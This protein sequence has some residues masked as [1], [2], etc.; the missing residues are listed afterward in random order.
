MMTTMN[1]KCISYEFQTL[2]S[3]LY[4]FY[5]LIYYLLLFYICEEY[6]Y[7]CFQRTFINHAGVSVIHVGPCF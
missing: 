3:D 5:Y 7:L 1:M 2:L 6:L 4:P